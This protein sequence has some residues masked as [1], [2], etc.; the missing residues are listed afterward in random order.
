MIVLGI[1]ALGAYLLQILFAIKQMKNFNLTYQK[2]RRQGKVAIGRRAGRIKAGTI[3]MFSVDKEGTIIGSEKMQ[4]V[5]VLAKF[6]SISQFNQQNIHDLTIENEL[7]QKENKLTQQTI[8]N[9]R[10]IYLRVEAGNY[11]EEDPISPLMKAKVQGNIMLE[12]IQKK[13]KR[14]V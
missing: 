6:K 8:L 13:F 10:D 5:T 12:S 11:I 14:G 9:A 4:G 2:L 7:V 1:F 3:V